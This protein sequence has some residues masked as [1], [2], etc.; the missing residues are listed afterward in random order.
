MR[1]KILLMLTVM[2]F[3]LTISIFPQNLVYASSGNSGN[4]KIEDQRNYYPETE[5]TLTIMNLTTNAYYG[6][7]VGANQATYDY[8][9]YNFT[10]TGVNMEITIIHFKGQ[11][12]L[13]V[14]GNEL[15]RLQ[16]NLY[17]I[18]NDSDTSAELLDTIWYNVVSYDNQLPEEFFSLFIVSAVFIIV[19][20]NLV[21]IF[22]KKYV[23]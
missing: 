7:L 2:T 10:A 22:F 8:N 13:D 16:I 4:F 5:L 6:L 3:M 20:A 19:I 11:S 18:D 21:I 12:L 9:W 17:G 14:D 1:F 15:Y 23:I